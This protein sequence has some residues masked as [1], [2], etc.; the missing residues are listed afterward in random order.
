MS[1]PNIRNRATA[2][3]TIDQTILIV[4]IIAILV[5]L[6][7][8]TIGWQL[9]NR[10]SG[11]KLAA[12][13][14]QVEDANGQFFS[15][16]RVWPHLS[17]TGSNNNTTNI[18]ALAGTITYTAGLVGTTKNYIPGLRDNG[19]NVTHNFSSTGVVTMAPITTPFAQLQGNYLVVQFSAVPM[20]EAREAEL[21]IDA[22]RN[23][24]ENYTAGRFVA[25]SATCLVGGSTAVSAPAANA[26]SV[27]ACYAANNID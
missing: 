25:S 24:T 1:V 16:N 27:F 21:A 26:T 2:G 23:G 4:A 20:T 11:A 9:I 6:I 10:T 13:L 19:T 3:Y 8:I 22:G 5:T 14:R 7:I 12:Q 18:R 17:Y 15:A